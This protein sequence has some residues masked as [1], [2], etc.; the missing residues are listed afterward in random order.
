VVVSFPKKGAA[1][2]MDLYYPDG[3]GGWELATKSN[4][5]TGRAITV[6]K[7]DTVTTVLP[8]VSFDL[9][10]RLP[11]GFNNFK[12]DKDIFV[13][14]HTKKLDKDYD[15]DSIKLVGTNMNICQYIQSLDQCTDTLLDNVYDRRAEFDVTF[16]ISF[17]GRFINASVVPRRKDLM[18][19]FEDE[20]YRF[21][22]YLKKRMPKFDIKRYN[23][24]HH[25][26]TRSNYDPIFNKVNRM[27][28]YIGEYRRPYYYTCGSCFGTSLSTR[29]IASFDAKNWDKAVD[30]MSAEGA[31][32]FLMSTA[33]LG[34]INCDHPWATG[35][36]NITYSVSV[37]DPKNTVAYLVFD[38]I[39][40]IIS[41]TY[42][43]V[44][45][46][47]RNVPMGRAV[48]IITISHL[49]SKPVMATMHTNVSRD[50]PRMEGFRE[51]TLARL[52]HEVN[53]GEAGPL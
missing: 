52:E 9:V 34:W 14:N 53:G 11:P 24:E 51:F 4:P 49:D 35:A 1:E 40:G 23:A 21:A 45:L 22:A 42:H 5:N 12:K 30:K 25:L 8:N 7:K 38:D 15:L 31:D 17:S 26:S 39:K 32:Y 19:D 29:E 47:F 37:P 36:E 44:N 48:K 27:T 10:Q 2:K 6:T 43:G 16:N 13:D 41:G 28:V 50:V 33:K 18:G 3:R 20:G 46:E